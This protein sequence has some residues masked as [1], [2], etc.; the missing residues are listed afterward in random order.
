ML[1]MAKFIVV[2][3]IKKYKIKVKLFIRHIY[4]ITVNYKSFG[5]LLINKELKK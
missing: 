3:T 4:Q 1:V 5:H 2:V